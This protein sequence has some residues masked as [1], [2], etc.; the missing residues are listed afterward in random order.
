MTNLDPEKTELF[1]DVR[2][3]QAL[4]YGLDRESIVHDILLDQ[5][6]VAHGTQPVISF[7]YA[8]DRI[9]TKYTFDPEKAKSLLAEAGWTDSDGDG[10][11]D[12]DGE[13]FAFEFIYPSGTPTTDQII[14]YMQDAWRQIGVNA[15]PRALEFP[16]LVQAI[17]EEHDFEVALLGF[18]WDPSFI[19][20][21]MFGCEQSYKGGFNMVKYCNERVDE[22]NAQAK[23]TFDDD[24]RRELLIEA[25]NL[26]NED[27]PV[28][29]MH[30]S[31]ANI[32][33]NERLQNYKPGSWGQHFEYVWV[34]Q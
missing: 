10:I 29:V 26:I 30:F 15:T 5:A 34:Q 17:S 14:A 23:R 22:L 25:T 9:T 8:P 1:Q 21:A 6:I 11:V 7:A 4:L 12:K 18:G 31:K 28:A 27:L 2:V 19:Q 20:D 32:G 3:R 33:Y 24:A 16:A 13:P